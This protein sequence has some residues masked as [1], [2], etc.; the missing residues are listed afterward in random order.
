VLVDYMFGQS[1]FVGVSVAVE[2]PEFVELDVESAFV[3]VLVAAFAAMAPP[4]TRAPV[5]A[6]AA[7]AFRKRCIL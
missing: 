5:T 7:K 1:A 4:N 2:E 6:E 3:V